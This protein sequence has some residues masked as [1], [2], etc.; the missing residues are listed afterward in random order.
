MKAF[1]FPGQG[2]Q[3]C[4]MAKEIYDRYP[5]ARTLMERAD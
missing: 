4:G 5:E 2:S 3:Y 1:V